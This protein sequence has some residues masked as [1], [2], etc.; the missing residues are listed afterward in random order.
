MSPRS[1]G[2]RGR[3]FDCARAAGDSP[4]RPA[5]S[6]STERGSRTRRSPRSRHDR[7]RDRPPTPARERRGRSRRG[8]KRR[9]AGWRS[10]GVRDARL[11][12]GRRC[13]VVVDG[14]SFSSEP[15]APTQRGPKGHASAQSVGGAPCPLPNRLPRRPLSPGRG[16]RRPMLAFDVPKRDGSSC[17]IAGLIAL[18]AAGAAVAARPWSGSHCCWCWSTSAPEGR[19]RTR[20]T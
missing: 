16:P 15:D 7:H 17:K 9:R 3:A 5:R 6:S 4:P 12:T 13:A 19:R 20:R 10:S 18:A 2:M 8:R 1:I 14:H 11:H